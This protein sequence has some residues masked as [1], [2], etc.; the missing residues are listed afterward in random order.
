MSFSELVAA[1]SFVLAIPQSIA[2]VISIATVI[3]LRRGSKGF[4]KTRAITLGTMSFIGV[5]LCLAFGLLLLRK[6]IEKPCTITQQQTGNATTRGQNSPANSGNGNT[7][8]YGSPPQP[9]PKT[10]P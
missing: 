5:A 3:S 6:P 7:T 4:T 8:T 9:P 10:N 1:G 2:A